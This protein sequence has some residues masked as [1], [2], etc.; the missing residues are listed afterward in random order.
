MPSVPAD[1]MRWRH[2]IWITV[3]MIQSLLRA[4]WIYIAII[5]QR[6]DIIQGDSTLRQ[7]SYD[8]FVMGKNGLTEKDFRDSAARLRCDVAAI[9]A[10]G[11]VESNGKPF[12]EDGFPVILFE[13]HIFHRFSGGKY[14]DSHPE[15]SNK[16]AGGY[17]KTGANQRRK[18]NI[19]FELDPIA[20]MK[21]CSW[22]RFQIMG[23]NH[24]LAGFDSVGAFVDAMKTSEDAQLDAFCEF[25]INS[26]LGD[27]L[28]K[29]QWESF[30]RQYNGAGYR[31]N[32]Y[33]LKLAIAYK[34]FVNAKPIADPVVKEKIKESDVLNNNQIVSEPAGDID[35]PNTVSTQ[36]KIEDGK[37]EVDQNTSA[38]ESETQTVEAP[39][40]YGF[41]KK[42]WMD[43][44]LLAGGN[45]TIQAIKEFF[46]QILQIP[47]SREFWIFI[48][49]LAVVISIIVIIARFVHYRTEAKRN[50]ETLNKRIDVAADPHK[51]NIDITPNR[52]SAETRIP[53]TIF[54]RLKFVIK[55]T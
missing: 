27:E 22:G 3:L 47:L 19:A 10:V 5:Q 7:Q 53:D 17:G 42:L 8:R 29:R 23:F 14:D 36:V 37:V 32:K 46:D 33:H 49:I 28:R 38:Q 15:I 43:I 54:G 12:Y 55:G 52:E 41:W 39:A 34:K 6:L 24:K 25:I 13:R 26:G 50:Q 30:A 35:A 11:E 48:T 9:K 45:I 18:F 21:S 20:A 2:F 44:K 51:N 31:K 1:R 16:N 40:A 4:T